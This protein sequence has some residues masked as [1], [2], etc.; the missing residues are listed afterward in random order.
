MLAKTKNPQ[1]CH[2]IWRGR[3]GRGEGERG[4][5]EKLTREGRR[6]RRGEGVVVIDEARA[7]AAGGAPPAPPLLPLGAL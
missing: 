2:I 5:R 7:R 3:E 4:E 6:A 1:F